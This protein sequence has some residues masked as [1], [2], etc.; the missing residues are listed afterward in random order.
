[1]AFILQIACIVHRDH[2][3]EAVSTLVCTAHTILHVAGS[4]LIV[5]L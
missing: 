1:M 4:F 3:S 2:I 5:C